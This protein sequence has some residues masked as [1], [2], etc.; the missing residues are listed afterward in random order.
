MHH[1]VDERELW[2]RCFAP[3][4]DS[5]TRLICF[6]HAGGSAPSEY[7]L[8]RVRDGGEEDKTGSSSVGRAVDRT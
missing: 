3:A 8:S 1:D 2:L 5:P 7:V 4:P 6:P